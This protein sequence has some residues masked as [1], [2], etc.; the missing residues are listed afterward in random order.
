MIGPILTTLAVALLVSGYM[1]I[2]NRMLRTDEHWS[3]TDLAPAATK[4]S[5]TQSYGRPAKQAHA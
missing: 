3:E 1:Y 5:G 4:P 2:V